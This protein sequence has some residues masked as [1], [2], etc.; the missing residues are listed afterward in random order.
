MRSSGGHSALVRLWIRRFAVDF[1]AYRASMW[2][3]AGR[4]VKAG[5]SHLAPRCQRLLLRKPGIEK[6]QN[7]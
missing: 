6:T 5:C 2:L 1:N 3:Q 7:I 4:P